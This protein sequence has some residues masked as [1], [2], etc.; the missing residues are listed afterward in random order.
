[1]AEMYAPNCPLCGE[2]ATLLDTR[3]FG[4]YKVLECDACGQFAISDHAES[5]IADLPRD[6][7]DQWRA[8]I[9]S[10]RIDEVLLIT[11]E[12]VGSGGGVKAEHVLRSSLRL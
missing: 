11:V 9:K 1:M 2:L 3:N 4:K 5:R 12:P 8:A 10:G 7:K 6:F